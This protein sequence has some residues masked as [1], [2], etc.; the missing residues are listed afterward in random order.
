MC[1]QEF[2]HFMLNKFAMQCIRS[3]FMVDESL[4]QHICIIN[5]YI[6]RQFI[7]LR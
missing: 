1:I 4:K 7:A 2:I 5:V 6:F 3:T